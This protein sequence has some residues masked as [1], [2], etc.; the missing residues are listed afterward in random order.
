M[1]KTEGG[2][3]RFVYARNLIL[4]SLI[5][6][7]VVFQLNSSWRPPTS[8]RIDIDMR[9]KEQRRQQEQKFADVALEASSAGGG[10]GCNQTP[11]LMQHHKTVSR[12]NTIAVTPRRDLWGYRHDETWNATGNSS[13]FE[14]VNE[15]E[16]TRVP[17]VEEWLIDSPLTHQISIPKVI[18]KV[19]MSSGGTFPDFHNQTTELRAAHETWVV[20][21][22]GYELRYFDLV[23]IR[24]YLATHFHPVFLRAF[25]CL[26]AYAGKVNLFRLAVLYRDGGWYSDW[27]EECLVDGLLD[28]LSANNRSLV[29]PWDQGTPHSRQNACIMNAFL[30]ATERNPSKWRTCC[31]SVILFVLYVLLFLT[32]HICIP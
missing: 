11:E 6:N 5:I 14:L 17:P 20:R 24:R 2:G 29:F 25:D 28:N 1:E 4:S 27:K 7:Y 21:N 13:S 18:Y 16:R 9:G 3:R 15:A 12:L 26:E 30:G 22:P 23:T 8:S 31:F 19:V 32:L 10:S